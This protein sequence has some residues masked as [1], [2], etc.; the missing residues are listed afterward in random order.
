MGLSRI[1]FLILPLEAILLAHR[2]AR[3]DDTDK[4]KRSC[5]FDQNDTSQCRP[6][7]CMPSP[8]MDENMVTAGTKGFCGRCTSDRFCGGA[9]CS[10]DT[11]LCVS[12]FDSSP[13]PRPV[14]PH[15]HLAVADLAFNFLDATSP[16]P[17]VSAGYMFQ[18]AFHKTA[19]QK[20]DDHG[21]LTTNLP[22]LYW[23]VGATIALAGPAQNVF[24]DAGLTLYVPSAPLWITTVTL[25]AE[26]QNLGSAIW[27]VWDSS[28][29]EYRLGPS[30]SVGVLQNVFVRATYVFPL[31]GA[32]D[33]HALI[34]GVSY[35]KDLLADLVPDRFRK[36]LPSV[37]K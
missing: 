36:F 24:A 17:I 6:W 26:L 10:L 14:W 8:P 23:T 1:A 33:H 13:P 28:D 2:T 30:L 25:G 29:T 9:K 4:S 11:G 18:G 31:W 34:F 7:G 15:F 27:K 20:Y 22:S 5:T 35:M 16:K 37:L 3:A 19:P 32:T 21:Y 12:K